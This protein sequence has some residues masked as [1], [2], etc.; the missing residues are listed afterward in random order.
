M[1]GDCSL[2]HKFTLEKDAV[3]ENIP[4]KIQRTAQLITH[5]YGTFCFYTAFA[6]QKHVFFAVLDCNTQP[7][8]FSAVFVYHLGDFSHRDIRKEHENPTFDSKNF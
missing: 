5:Q 4:T 8:P 6:D 7:I 1:E 3:L 2:Q